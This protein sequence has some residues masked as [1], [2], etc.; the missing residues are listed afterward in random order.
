MRKKGAWKKKLDSMIVWGKTP[1]DPEL[2][3]FWES[4]EFTQD[5]VHNPS[6]FGFLKLLE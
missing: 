2:F 6:P 1:K 5:M 3:V 4:L